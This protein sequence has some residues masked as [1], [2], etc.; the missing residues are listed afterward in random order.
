MH[1]KFFEV[2]D[3]HLV[4]HALDTALQ[5]AVAPGS[6]VQKVQDQWLPLAADDAQG[7][8]KATNKTRLS[9]VSLRHS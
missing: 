2:L 7:S 1:L 8:V 6:L 3:Q 4:A 9:S 5:L